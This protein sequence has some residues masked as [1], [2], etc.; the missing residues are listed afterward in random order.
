MVW[1]MRLNRFLV[2]GMGHYTDTESSCGI[3]NMSLVELWYGECVT[4]TVVVWRMG[5]RY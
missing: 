2:W 3:G 5:I 4:S 1:G